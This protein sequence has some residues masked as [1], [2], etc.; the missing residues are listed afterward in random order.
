MPRRH[1]ETDTILPVHST[2]SS[3]GGDYGS[4]A[5]SR[6]ADSSSASAAPLALLAELHLLEHTERLRDHG[7]LNPY[8]L[9]EATLDDLERAGVPLLHRRTLLDAVATAGLRPP[10]AQRQRHAQPEPEKKVIFVGSAGCGKSQ[11]VRRFVDNQFEEKSG[12]TIG[13]DALPA[14]TSDRSPFR[15]Q[16]LGPA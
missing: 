2:S 7:L 1:G 9:E 15:A 12:A 13:C 6:P 10:A 11:I 5:V 8:R 4:G 3:S 16:C 14:R